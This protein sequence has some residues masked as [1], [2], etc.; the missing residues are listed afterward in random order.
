MIAMRKLP[1][2]DPA[3]RELLH[4]TLRLR[5]ARPEVGL[6]AAHLGQISQPVQLIWGQ[7]DPFGSPEVGRRAAGLIPQAEFHMIPETG[8][9]PWV[10]HARQVGELAAPFLAAAAAPA[11]IGARG[12]FA[13]AH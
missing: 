1:R 7:N 4:A 8:H 5:G 12:P 6:T 2:T 9:V 11:G 3:L 13:T 10:D